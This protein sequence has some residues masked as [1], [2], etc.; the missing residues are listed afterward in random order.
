MNAKKL[1]RYLHI[2]QSM[3]KL[4]TLYTTGSIFNATD[5]LPPQP[6][7]VGNLYL[8]GHIFALYSVLSKDVSYAEKQRHC[9]L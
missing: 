7:G 5:P 8:K 6:S 3:I 4:E 1:S 9:P 2:K